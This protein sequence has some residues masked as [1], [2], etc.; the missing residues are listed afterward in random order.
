M[1]GEVGFDWRQ[2]VTARERLRGVARRTP[3]LVAGDLDEGVSFYVKAESLQL[4]HAFKF[5]GAY[6]RTSLL[7]A[8]ERR[9]GLVAAS[10]GNH[11]LGLSLAGRM[12]GARVTVVMPTGAPAVKEQGC[13]RYGAEVVRAGETYDDAVR[14]AHELA[15]RCGFTY[16]QSFDDPLVAAGQATVA[17]EMLEDL[18]DLEVIVAPI[19]GGGLLSGLLGLIKTMPQEE[20]R[21]WFPNRS[22]P[23]AAISVVGVQ[24]AGAAS[25][26]QS[27]WAGRRLSLP[28]IDTVADG[29]AVRQPGAWTFEVIRRLVDDLVTVSDQEMLA[30][31]GAM[32]VR[33]KLVV[34]PA[35]AA[36]VA[37]LLARKQGSSVNLGRELAAGRRVAAVIS[38]GNVEPHLLGGAIAAWSSSG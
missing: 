34:E 10:S 16:V 12:L 6:Y 18:P 23:L 25:T 36:A 9:A 15:G 13:R 24:A 21:V 11:A 20:A 3:M 32:A 17:W 26:V 1:S 27:V 7:T 28:S 2:V 38:G 31:L 8:E 19:G 37:A 33:E 14:H 4:T 5:R 30:A 35:G 29:I 22:K